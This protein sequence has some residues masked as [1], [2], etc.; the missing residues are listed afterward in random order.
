MTRI[1]LMIGPRHLVDTVEKRCDVSMEI[2][3]WN[4]IPGFTAFLPFINFFNKL[5]ESGR[6]L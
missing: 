6:A 5:E 2:D 4:F 3:I 1:G